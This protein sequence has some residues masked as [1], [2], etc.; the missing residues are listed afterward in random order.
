VLAGSAASTVAEHTLSSSAR[1]HPTLARFMQ[2]SS[3]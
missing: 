2:R 1:R 3:A